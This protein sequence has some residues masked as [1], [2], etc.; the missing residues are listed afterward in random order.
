MCVCLLER[1][2]V[3]LCTSYLKP[4][5]ETRLGG[6]V[7]YRPKRSED[8][9][10]CMDFSLFSVFFFVLSETKLLHSKHG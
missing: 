6:G 2:C 8:L 5:G 1:V 10:S 3:K 9:A 4:C 7:I